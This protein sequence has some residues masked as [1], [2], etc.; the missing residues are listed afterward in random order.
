M[1]SLIFVGETFN[2]FFFLFK[3]KKKKKKK[4]K[5]DLLTG[6]LI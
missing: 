2:F 3:K 1:L 4:K 6:V 5:R